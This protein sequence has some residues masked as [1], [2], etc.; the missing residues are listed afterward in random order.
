VIPTTPDKSMFSDGSATNPLVGDVLFH[1]N[2][3]NMAGSPA[4]GKWYY[5]SADGYFY[6][7]GK[8]APGA[9][10]NELLSSIELDGNNSTSAWTW[11]E[12][13]LTIVVESLQATADALGDWGLSTASGIGQYLANLA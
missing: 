12:Y 7:G 3:A 8:L 5:N 11:H 13:A 4:D 10:T 1:L 9:S 6:W 2:A